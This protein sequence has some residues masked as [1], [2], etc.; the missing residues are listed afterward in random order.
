MKT[1]QLFL[2]AASIFAALFVNVQK[3][4]DFKSLETLPQSLELNDEI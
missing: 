2:V 3:Q 1:V 4:F